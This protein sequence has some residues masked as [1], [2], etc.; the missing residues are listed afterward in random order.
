[1][2]VTHWHKRNIRALF[3]LE[4]QYECE[5]A[6]SANASNEFCYIVAT[7]YGKE[8]H[9]AK[10]ANIIKAYALKIQIKEIKF[11]RERHANSHCT[12]PFNNLYKQIPHL[13]N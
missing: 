4:G 7:L 10:Y 2:H 9:I 11:E 6:S 5:L 8:R 12:R 1:M 13:A 3:H